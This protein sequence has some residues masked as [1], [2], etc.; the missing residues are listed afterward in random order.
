MDDWQ[1]EIPNSGRIIVERLVIADRFWK[2]F[3]GLQFRRVLAPGCGLLLTPCGS[4]HTMCMRFTIDVAMLNRT[5]RVLAVHQTVRPWR[6]VLAP[7]GTHAVLE[8]PAG[9]PRLSVNDTLALRSHTGRTSPP[10]SMAGFIV[11][12]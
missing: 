12:T 11:V 8:T 6:L 5:G 10:P 7:R 4:I 1:L 2:R 9:V 3:C